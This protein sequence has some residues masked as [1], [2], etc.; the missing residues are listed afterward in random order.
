MNAAGF[1]R[2][3]SFSDYL[4]L[5]RLSPSGA[6]VLTR[7][8]AHYRHYRD[9]PP[10]ETPALRIGK[11]VHALALEGRAAYEAAFAVAPECDRRTR[12]GKAV[13]GDFIA[14]SEGRTVLTVT[15]AEL[16]EGMAGGIL[17]HHLAPAL[18]ADG[19]PELSMLW[20]DPETGTPCKGRMDLARLEVG[21]ILDLKSTLDAS[22][23]AFA[24]SCLAYGYHVQQAAYMAGAA[25]LRADVRD[26]VILAVEKAP[27]F[28]VGIYRLPDAALELGR[29]RWGE[30]CA[31]YAQCLESGRWPGYGEGIQE[32]ALP[33]WAMS[34]LYES[35]DETNTEN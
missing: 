9:N 1:H 28:A 3:L 4:A 7:S 17:S 8:A 29:R 26:F 2:D 12:E 23:A 21:A 33:N 31:L 6:K 24:R 30:A 15:E 35:I 13:W 19:T 22:P 18:L 5:D 14:A 20:D 27:P 11:A 16:V 10:T 34:E 32:L 25:A